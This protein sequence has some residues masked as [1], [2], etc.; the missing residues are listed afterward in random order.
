MDTLPKHGVHTHQ[1]VTVHSLFEDKLQHCTHS[2][3]TG[4]HSVNAHNSSTLIRKPLYTLTKTLPQHQL[5]TTQQQLVGGV[6]ES[7]SAPVY[8]FQAPG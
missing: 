4:H 6:N 1:L 5:T 8:S 7:T 3:A 2:V